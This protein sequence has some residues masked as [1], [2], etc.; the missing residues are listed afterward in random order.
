MTAETADHQDG[1]EPFRRRVIRLHDREGLSRF[2]ADVA[3]VA[4]YA[5]TFV[6]VAVSGGLTYLYVGPGVRE[7]NPVTYGLIAWFGPGGMVAARFLVVIAAFWGYH[8]LR[9]QWPVLTVAFAWIGALI[10]LLDAVHDARVA[11]TAAEIG[12][13]PVGDI[14]ALLVVLAVGAVAGILLRPPTSPGSTGGIAR[15]QLQESG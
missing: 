6:G 4:A 8:F 2:D 9:G 1:E 7:L 10:H 5:T 15:L 14:P 13:V 3:F 12:F 11:L